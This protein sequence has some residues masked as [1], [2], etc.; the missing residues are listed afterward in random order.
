MES[1]SVRAGRFKAAYA[2]A[3]GETTWSATVKACLD[4]LEDW[5]EGANLGFL[6][7]TDELAGDLGSILTFLRERSGIPH[8][9]GTVGLGIVASGREIYDRPALSILVGSFGEDSFRVFEV[10]GDGPPRA[11]DSHGDWI[12]SRHPILG[13]V[14]GDPRNGG[15]VENIEQV[16][17]DTSAFLVGGLTAARDAMPQV[18]DRVSEGGLSGVLFASDQLVVAGLTQGCTPI[19]DYRKITS[20]EGTVIKELDGR[21]AVEVLCEDIGELLARDLRRIGGYIFAAFP[22]P[23]SDT[24]DFLV[25]NLLAIDQGQ[26]WIEVAQE[27]ATGDSVRFCRRDHD[28][29]QRDLQRMLDDVTGRAGGVPKAALYHACIARGR[30]LFG[31]DS[32]ELQQIQRSLGEVPLTGFFANGEISNNRLY[33]YTGVLTLLL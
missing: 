25:R 27:V 11:T 33:A 16:A 29:A 21:P 19:G 7:A 18:A 17:A 5:P 12:A 26:G 31:P 30:N 13:V 1:G 6:Y 2:A 32:E 3:E 9:C 20:A 28:S 8:W 10:G 22:I 23:G 24:A 14:H 15:L 4:A